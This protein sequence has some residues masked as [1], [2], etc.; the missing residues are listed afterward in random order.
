MAR[1]PNAPRAAMPVRQRRPACC[2]IL[3]ARGV[4]HGAWIH[5]QEAL[6]SLNAIK[7]KEAWSYE[8]YSIV[9]PC[10]RVMAERTVA[11]EAVIARAKA[12]QEKV[13]QEKAKP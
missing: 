5:P 13:E 4:C 2:A 6:K 9:D 10:G 7:P 12:E 8:R 11:G 1:Y 3:D